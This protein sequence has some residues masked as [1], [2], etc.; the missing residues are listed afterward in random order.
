MSERT[1]P[2]GFSAFLCLPEV[3]EYFTLLHAPQLFDGL[4]RDMG[5]E[6]SLCSLVWRAAARFRMNGC[7][8]ERWRCSGPKGDYYRQYLKPEFC[9]LSCDCAQPS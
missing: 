5:G 9:R 2:G 8:G 3:P 6:V 7:Q 4:S 1:R